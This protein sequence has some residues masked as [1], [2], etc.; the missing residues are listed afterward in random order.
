MLYL[1]CM[2]E[3]TRETCYYAK[4]FPRITI[5]LSFEAE[6]PGRKVIPEVFEM[7][8]TRYHSIIEFIKDKEVLEVGC[9]PGLGLG[10]IDQ[11]AKRIIGGDYSI[12]NVEIA[13]KHYG[14]RIEILVLNAHNLP[15]ES[16]SFD[17]I[18]AMEVLLYLDV[19]KFLLECYNVLRSNGMV[20]ACIPNK[21]SPSF[22]PSNL[23]RNYFSV[24]ELYSLFLSN[25]FE[26][27]LYG[28]FKIK[29]ETSD[30]KLWNKS[31]KFRL[32]TIISRILQVV[33]GGKP[34]KNYLGKKIFKKRPLPSELRPNMVKAGTLT[35]LNPE[36]KNDENKIIYIFALKKN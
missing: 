10:Y 22:V 21:D 28:A 13:H 7:I 31:I 30:K 36:M 15:F 18:I 6:L 3:A 8:F 26:P 12:S 9:G 34:I 14:K 5:T 19:Q 2:V 33:P 25:N 27:K 23:S 16:E 17:V 4:I 35:P 29:K 11:Y 1:I 24:P 32:I 20:L